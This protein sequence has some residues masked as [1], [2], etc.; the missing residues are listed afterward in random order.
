MRLGSKELDKMRI[1]KFLELVVAA[2]NVRE[3]EIG[4]VLLWRKRRM[5]AGVTMRILE[6]IVGSTVL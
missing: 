5:T 2:D 3:A 6:N 1:L 4:L